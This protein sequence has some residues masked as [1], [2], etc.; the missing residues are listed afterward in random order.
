[1][2]VNEMSQIALE[3]HCGGI[4]VAFNQ[5]RLAA[6]RFYERQGFINSHCKLTKNLLYERDC[7]HTYNSSKGQV[8]EE[9]FN[10]IVTKSGLII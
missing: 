8:I 10:A 1:M 2:L 3:N 7:G 6:H 4:E 9:K 5:S